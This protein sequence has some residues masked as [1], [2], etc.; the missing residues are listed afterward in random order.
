MKKLQLNLEK[1][2]ILYPQLA[3]ALG[4]IEEAIYWQQLYYWSDK[5]KDSWIYKTKEEIEK[6]TALTR[7]QQDRVRKK[8]EKIGAITTLLKKANGSPTLHFKVDIPIV[9]NLLMEKQETYYSNS[10]KLTN[11]SYTEN[12][13]ENTTENS[14]AKALQT[15]K[16]EIDNLI[17]Q[18]K[19][20]KLNNGRQNVIPNDNQMDKKCI[21]VVN[22]GKV[23]LDKINI[24]QNKVLQT[25]GKEIN[26]LISLFKEVNPSYQR[27]FG[28]KTQR[29]ALER[30]VKQ[31]GQEKIEWAI[32]VL[33][34]TN[35]TKFA[36][37]ITTP[38]MLES[39]LGQLIAFMQKE[40]GENNEY[41]VA[42][43]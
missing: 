2:V 23:R 33:P 16:K 22:T 4:G 3:K 10:K 27:L 37:V 21:Q 5:G 31:H 20:Y 29:S 11:P 8:L 28:N 42:K 38:Y 41:K 17:E 14:K 13:T 40:S 26:D 7:Y 30:L 1:P 39:K 25:N 36:P 35:K 15:N 12:T 43:I 19:K 24:K 18:D 34:K 6:E 32:K 9:R